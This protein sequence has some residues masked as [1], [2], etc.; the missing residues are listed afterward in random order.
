MLVVE[1]IA[2]YFTL[3][4]AR[5]LRQ[6]YFSLFT[7]ETTCR[8]GQPFMT[9]VVKVA[10]FS[11]KKVGLCQYNATCWLVPIYTMLPAGLC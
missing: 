6:G 5:Q 4:V 2:P 8:A 9:L 11:R 10:D 7:D 1:G 3:E